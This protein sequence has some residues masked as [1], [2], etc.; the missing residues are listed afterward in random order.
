M[1]FVVE[2]ITLAVGA[3]FSTIGINIL[4]EVARS[5]NWRVYRFIPS[6]IP[7]AISFFTGPSISFDVILGSLV[8]YLW[9]R[10]N[11]RHAELFMAFVGCGMIIGESFS[12]VIDNLMSYLNLTPPYCMRFLGSETADKVAG[13]LA[14]IP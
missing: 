2:Q 4:R 7:M 5:M 3:F 1:Y 13:F 12:P 6:L 8:A 9:R 14:M 11:K 10:K